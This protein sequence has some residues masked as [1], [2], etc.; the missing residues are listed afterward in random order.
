MRRRIKFRKFYFVKMTSLIAAGCV[1]AGSICF[2]VLAE[3]QTAEILSGN[4]RKES[5]Q[6][7]NKPEETTSG[8]GK[9]TSEN[10]EAEK[11]YG[12]DKSREELGD[13]GGNKNPGGDKGQQEPENLEGN[14]N[15]G[16]DKGEEEAKDT[17]GDQNSDG[18][19]EEEEVKDNEK[20][21]DPGNDKGESED[22]EKEPAADDTEE[23]K[24][25][26]KETVS[27][28]DVK[29][30]AGDVEEE[31]VSG[32]DLE[33]ESEDTEKADKEQEMIDIV[34]PAAYVLALNPYCLPIKVRE[35]EISEEQIISGT[36]GIVNKSF[37]DQ[38][39]TVSLTVEDSNGGEVVFVDSPE[40]AENAGKGICAIYLSV[41]PADEQEILID[42]EAVEKDVSGE[43]LQNVEMSGASEQAVTLHEGAN[44]IAFKLSGAVYEWETDE[45]A[46]GAVLIGLAP[47]GSGV[48][49]Y[50]FS[51]VM[52]PNAAWEELSGG[53][54]LS[55][56]YTY[57]TADG[58]E[59]VIEGT[60]AMIC[61][62]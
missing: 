46:A 17:E 29:E 33:K 50:T 11:A 54:K 38:I 2:P 44:Q 60:G 30:E 24:N 35:D 28:N 8:P 12:S 51:G 52:N 57:Q 39:V 25:G 47:D 3:E 45:E 15:S 22:P 34:V 42:G 26:E 48:T 13:T 21:K 32:N 62:D 43:A 36:Y 27:G 61:L 14:E 58:E 5:Q 10:S 4:V 55:V 19:K 37:T 6:E 41:V 9:E 53:I 40:E 1:L 20:E 56:V 31:T 59:E 49:A 7:K 18:G 23:S 16:G